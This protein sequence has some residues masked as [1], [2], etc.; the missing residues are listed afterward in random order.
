HNILEAATF[1]IP[2]IFGPKYQ[3]FREAKELIKQKGAFSVSNFS[4]L[5]SKL[6]E[7]VFD[8]DMLRKSGEISQ[9]YVIFNIGATRKII[10]EIR[11]YSVS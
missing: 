3:K 1:G 11:I 5:K 4:E 10:N 6:D 2:V 7:F 8:K 9:K